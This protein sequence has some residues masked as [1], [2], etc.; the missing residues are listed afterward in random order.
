MPDHRAKHIANLEAQERNTVEALVDHVKAAMNADS[1]EGKLHHETLA[2][3]ERER[4][5]S[6]R[7]DLASL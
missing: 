2:Q 7:K 6:I 3:V 5:A 4:L 1:T